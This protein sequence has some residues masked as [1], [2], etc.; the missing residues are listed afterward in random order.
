VDYIK[1]LGEPAVKVN[2]LRINMYFLCKILGC[3]FWVR[4]L[5]LA[6][7]TNIKLVNY[8]NEHIPLIQNLE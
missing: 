3:W 1:P 6:S 7:T 2:I 5:G 8:H 4:C